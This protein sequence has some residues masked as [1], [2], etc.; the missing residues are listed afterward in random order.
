MMLRKKGYRVGRVFVY[1]LF[2]HQLFETPWTVAWQARLSMGFSRQKCWSG[3]PFPA[4]GDLPDLGMEL[5]SPALAGRF[6]SAEPS[7]KPFGTLSNNKVATSSW[8][9]A[10]T[11]ELC[12]DLRGSEISA[13]ILHCH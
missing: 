13:V 1:L 6:F 7:G 4:P 12:E 2:S 11:L 9:K 10:L 3:L 8:I 5:E